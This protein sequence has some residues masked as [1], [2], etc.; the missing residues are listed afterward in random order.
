MYISKLACSVF[1]A[2]AAAKII[3]K[4]DNVIVCNIITMWQL[5][6]GFPLEFELLPVI[7]IHTF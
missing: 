2:S 3:S 1:A 7:T 4:R 5:G 6:Q